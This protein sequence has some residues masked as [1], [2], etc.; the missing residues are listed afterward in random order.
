MFCKKRCSQKFSKI[1]RKIP[2]PEAY[3]VW[4]EALVWEEAHCVK[5]VRIRNYSG[6]HFSRIFPHSDWI[7]R[8]TEYKKGVLKSLA[9]FTGKRPGVSWLFL[10]KDTPTQVPFC[11]FCESFKNSFFLTSPACFCIRSS[12][13]TSTLKNKY[14]NTV[15][16]QE[17]WW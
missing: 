15:K 8:D 12:A 16:N 11:E 17:W 6:P 3:V 10:E 9:K 13:I 7:W 4:E 14:W 2:V 5:S 1:H